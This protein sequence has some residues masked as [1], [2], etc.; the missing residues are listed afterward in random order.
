MLFTVVIPIYNSASYIAK[1]LESIDNASTALE[2]EILLIDDFS[3]DINDLR[4]IIKN[5]EKVKLIVKDK[6]SNAAD[7]R[8]IG[9]LKSHSRFV[10]FLDSDDHFISDAIDSRIDTHKECEA[11]V[12][13][14][15]FII[16][17]N[18]IESKSELPEY[19]QEDLRDYILIKK[20]DVRSSVLSIDK[21]FHK[22]T[23]FDS[24]SRKHQDWI[25]AF[26]CWDNEEKIVFDE[27]YNTI[28]NFDRDTRMSSSANPKAS[29][30]LVENY[31]SNVKHINKFSEN[32]WRSTI[33]QQDTEACDFFIS[34]YQ[35]QNISGFVKLNFYKVMSTKLVLP[36]SSDAITK[37]RTL[38]YKYK[39]NRES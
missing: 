10:F 1:T 27:Q 5:F 36:L 8:N 19:N 14:S 22:G 38:K 6:K 18:G 20:G 33:S 24:E 25:F 30:Y 28:I 34:I 13:F 35:P 7:S 37:I 23:L 11:G 9:F 29:K 12:I 4:E 2:Y 21:N 39:K 16:N 26:K 31:L 32:N 15:N 3:N 17:R